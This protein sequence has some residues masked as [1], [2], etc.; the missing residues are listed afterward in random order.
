MVSRMGSVG[1]ALERVAVLVVVMIGLTPSPAAAVEAAAQTD[2]VGPP[3]SGEFGRSVT[4][5]PNG[6]I[7]VTDPRYSA[8]STAWVGAVYLYDGATGMLVS[9]LTGSTKYD[10]VG[11]GGVTVLS[12]GNYLVG[13]PDWNNGGI[14]D[15]GA[16]TWGSGMTGIS[17]VVSSTTSLVG[18]SSFDRVG[19]SGVSA[20][21]NGNYV[22]AA[23]YWDGVTTD[24]GAVTWGDGTSGITGVIS[25]TN[26]LMGSS[27]GDK[28][29]FVTA[30]SNGN[31]VV[32]S[33]YWDNGGAT[34]AGAVT[35][36]D[37]ATGTT[38][39]VSAT[40]SLVGSSANDSVGSFH[41]TELANANYVV[42]SPYWD[43]GPTADVG[44]VT[45]GDGTT[46][47]SGAVSPANS[48][49]GGTAT[50]TVGS[51]GIV[52][53]TNGNYV[54]RSDLWDDGV[55]A[56]V[57]AATWGDGTV[58][59]SGPVTNTNSLVGGTAG[60]KAGWVQVVALSNGNYVVCTRNWHNEGKQNVGAVTWG[61]GTIGV[62]GVISPSNSLVG[63]TA[64]D[65]VGMFGA[66]ALTNGNY[67]VGSPSWD[68]G[69]V[70]DVGAVTW[71]NGA[72]GTTGVVS[73]TN[74]LVGST[75]GD[76]IGSDDL[77]ALSNGNYVVASPYWD[78]GL[79]TDIGAVTWGD[80]STGTTGVVS[81]V[82]SLVG[83]TTDDR[84]GSSDV[85]AL[86]NG[87][88]VV[89]SPYWDKGVVADIGAVTWGDGTTGI[90]GVISS[91]NSL[92]GS[93]TEDWVGG[94]GVVALARG[95]FVVMS[96]H[97]DNG[98]TENVG[99]VTWASGMT[100]ISGEI[101]VANSLIGGTAEDQIGGE[102]V[103]LDNGD[104]VVQSS[105]WDSGGTANAGAVTWGIGPAGTKGV[106]TSANSVLGTAEDGGSS[107]VYAY[108]DVNRQLV[109]G[110][111]AD[112]V[113]TLFKVKYQ[114]YLPLVSR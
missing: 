44:A 35:W 102:V 34:D 90:N 79:L 101:S 39:V 25:S 66:T 105:S 32:R 53:L 56:D 67:L 9:T 30:L 87:N 84:V 103:A 23:T 80:G 100:A 83:S 98:V 74:S 24:V 48:L 72:T 91:G 113:V 17:G 5:L 58:G 22:V 55:K 94:S 86:S 64:N 59:I 29:G 99:A 111:P 41:L 68:N 97:W 37:G 75:S 33:P 20:L 31:Y 77:A 1:R 60:D 47:V 18:S 8:G 7:V 71:G 46:G 89:V 3:G 13:S 4:V 49:V 108:D 16:V 21:S 109:V 81:S 78:N 92:V 106:I 52:A 95:D 10:Q 19:Q 107:M 104:Y 51:R 40:N 61:D 85:I 93:M 27:T 112:N 63:T 11:S 45:W 15:A 2:L 12:N 54:V 42:S 6:N 114:V 73:S 26:S 38:G 69:L 88:Y 57:G 96:S 14:S 50:D 65:Y 36:C 43:D 110:R 28:V 76:Q 62:S 70:T 82:N